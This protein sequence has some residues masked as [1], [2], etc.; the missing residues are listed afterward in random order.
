MGES[1]IVVVLVMTLSLRSM[2]VINAA[3]S[4]FEHESTNTFFL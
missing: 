3:T 4:L 2:G 1:F